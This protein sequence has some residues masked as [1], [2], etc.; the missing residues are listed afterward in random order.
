M[1]AVGVEGMEVD[2]FYGCGKESARALPAPALGL[3]NAPPIGGAITG[4]TEAGAHL[5]FIAVAEVLE[6][7]P[8]VI[9]VVV[10]GENVE[11]EE[12]AESDG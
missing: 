8:Q 7:I 11:D 10:A 1:L 9:E 3:A 2:V 12:M 6:L 4:A 5:R